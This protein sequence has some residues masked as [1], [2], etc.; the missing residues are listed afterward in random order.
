MP[1]IM[2]LYDVRVYKVYVCKSRA[3][4]PSWIYMYR[5]GGVTIYTSQKR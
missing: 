4:V 3:G 1:C 2:G 5:E